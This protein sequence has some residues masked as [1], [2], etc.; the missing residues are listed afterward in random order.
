MTISK[1]TH[2][3]LLIKENNI[4]ILVDPG[5]YTAD[6]GALDLK[7]I[8]HLDYL[9]Y[10]HE[11]MDHFYVPL[12]KLI[13]EKFPDVKIITNPSIV[14]LLKK[15]D[16]KASSE[17]SDIAQMLPIPHEKVFG[18]AKMCDN[19]QFDVFG[20]LTHPGDS[21]HFQ[22]S[23]PVLALP[24]QAPWGSLTE[25]VDYALKAQPKVI[26]PIHD[27]HWKDSA[28]TSFY[29]WLKQFFAAQDIDFRPLETGE[30]V[31]V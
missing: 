5:N 27:W 12:T 29:S 28:R 8:D 3:C 7:K 20:K 10:T 21:F 31:T 17:N 25:A 22:L 14:A 9:L 23:T 1:H 19:V 13:L 4:N 24:V 26:I 30:E 18:M 6:E 15:E 16:V 11:H 2:S